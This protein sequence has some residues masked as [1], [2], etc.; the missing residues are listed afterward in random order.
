M[1]KKIGLYAVIMLLLSL[2][3]ILSGWIGYDDLIPN[4]SKPTYNY[5]M[6][7]TEY[8][9]TNPL[10]SEQLL[11]LKDVAILYLEDRIA[12]LESTIDQLVNPNWTILDDS[13]NVFPTKGQIDQLKSEIVKLKDLLNVLS[14]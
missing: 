6:P 13:V 9:S 12:G 5:L 4:E 7:D 11:V 3:V 8:G 1:I 10:S 2:P 14:N